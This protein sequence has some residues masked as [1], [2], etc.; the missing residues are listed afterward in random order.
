MMSYLDG[1]WT[2]IFDMDGL[3]LDSEGLTNKAW[4]KAALDFGYNLTD[5]VMQECV[6]CSP[7]LSEFIQKKYLGQDYPYAKIRERKIIYFD[8]SIT[9]KGIPV[10]NGL[11]PLLDLLD[12]KQICKAVASSTEQ[13]YVNQRLKVTHLFE[14]FDVIVSGSEVE[15]VKPDPALFL[16]AARLIGAEP[17]RCLVLEDTP[18]GV[19]A[20]DAAG[21]PVILVPDLA[22]IPAEIRSMTIGV[23]PSLEE[24]RLFLLRQE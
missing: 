1:N 10:K 22:P 4:Q 12:S 9:K 6:G 24:V 13:P 20:A 23:F 8:E 19:K 15:K 17:G 21:M 2:F 11:L 14:R 7:V 5:E 18:F 16:E 3:M